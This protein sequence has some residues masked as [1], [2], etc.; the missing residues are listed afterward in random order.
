MGVAD[1][2]A[3]QPGEAQVALQKA[4]DLDFKFMEPYYPLTEILMAR[5]EFAGAE[6]LLQRAMEEDAQGWLWPYELAMCSARQS[7]WDKAV[8]YGQIALKRPSPAATVPP[9]M[10]DVSSAWGTTGE[11]MAA[12]FP[13]VEELAVT[14][15]GVGLGMPA[16]AFSSRWSLAQAG[17]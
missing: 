2:R 1:L 11:G 16:P 3:K 15:T 13:L 9:L 8:N 6:R 12:D 7:H 4:V 10:G 17:Q 5:K 14:C